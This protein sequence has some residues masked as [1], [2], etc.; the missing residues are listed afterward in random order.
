MED[1]AIELVQTAII[2]NKSILIELLCSS[3]PRKKYLFIYFC[4]WHG[5]TDGHFPTTEQHKNLNSKLILVEECVACIVH[6]CL[7]LNSKSD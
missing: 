6:I 7:T 3:L 1:T 4:P 2:K 5:T